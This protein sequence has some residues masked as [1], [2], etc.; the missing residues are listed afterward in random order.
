[1]A[2][3]RRPPS[4][5]PP[6]PRLAS[7]RG[8]DPAPHA[9]PGD[10]PPYPLRA[11]RPAVAARGDAPFLGVRSSTHARTTMTM[12]AF[13]AAV[14]QRGGAPGD[15]LEPRARVLDPR[16][17]R[18]GLRG[19]A[20]RRRSRRRRPR[21]TRRPDDGRHDRPDRGAHRAFGHP[22]RRRRDARADHQHP[23]RAAA[24]D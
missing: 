11:P 20:V 1:M 9:P 6:V 7:S 15:A 24:G 2:R 17:A 8:H 13:G 3:G 5:H 21:P 18:T 14:G 12:A 22:A 16:S 23:A 19:L 10:P 4:R